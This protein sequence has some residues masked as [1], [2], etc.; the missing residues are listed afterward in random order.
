MSVLE[1]TYI[2]QKKDYELVRGS[3]INTLLLMVKLELLKPNDRFDITVP[4]YIDKYA[5]TEKIA[6]IGSKAKRFF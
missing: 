5:T 2:V 6:R 4:E 1:Y 3:V